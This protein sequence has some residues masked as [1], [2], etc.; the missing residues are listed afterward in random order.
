MARVLKPGGLFYADI[1][2]RKFSLIGALDFLYPAPKGWYEAR[3]GERDIRGMIAAAG[4]VPLQ[5]FAAGVLPPR[6]IPGRGRLPFIEKIQRRLIERGQRFWR[7]LDGT[8]WARLLGFYY[9]VSAAKPPNHA[10]APAASK[11][12]AQGEKPWTC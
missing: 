7:A 6:N 11:R 5:L 2:P 12:R 1:C 3:L 8:A 4:L 9:Y 10:A